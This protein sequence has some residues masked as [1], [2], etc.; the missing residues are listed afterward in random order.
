MPEALQY[1]YT[2]QAEIE[3]AWS[4]IG[5]TLRI[6]DLSGTQLRDF[7]LDLIAEATDIVN[8]YC[9]HY[10][11]ES[12][13]NNSRWVR[14]RCK[15]IGAY[16]LSQRRGNPAV[17][18]ERY[19]EVISDLEKVYNGS[20]SIPRLPTSSDMTPALSNLV[21]DPTFLHKQLRVHPN[22]STGGTSARQDLSYRF[23]FDWI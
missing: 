6:D 4:S 7:W 19:E 5:V 14:S 20:I 17:F 13:L 12:D 3:F 11:S 23:P 21:V 9:L 15:W 2:S 18:R 8:Q 16:L 10:Y 1:T 22:I